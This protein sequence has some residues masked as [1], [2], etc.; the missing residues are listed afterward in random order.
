MR[1]RVKSVKF[2][3]RD[4]FNDRGTGVGTGGGEEGEKRKR[5][6]QDAA[7][8][9]GLRLY[10]AI[11]QKLRRFFATIVPTSAAAFVSALLRA[12]KRPSTTGRRNSFGALDTYYTLKEQLAR[13]S[14]IVYLPECQ[15]VFKASSSSAF[16][17]FSSDELRSLRFLLL[18]SQFPHCRL[19]FANAVTR[20]ALTISIRILSDRCLGADLSLTAE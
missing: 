12:I 3:R 13:A 5:V 7:R 20:C 4:P 1:A 11:R 2:S 8:V 15:E 19:L 17:P 10:G 6:I 14:R 18:M 9:C 16:C